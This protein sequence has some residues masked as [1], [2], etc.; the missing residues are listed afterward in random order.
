MRIQRRIE[1][2]IRGLGAPRPCAEHLVEQD[3]SSS[4]SNIR[5][6]VQMDFQ[7]CPVKR[8]TGKSQSRN[9]VAVISTANEDTMSEE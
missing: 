8:T 9:N 4:S 6:S 3:P 1:I 2:T 7:T 5:D